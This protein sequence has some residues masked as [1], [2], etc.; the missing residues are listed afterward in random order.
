[1][2]GAVVRTPLRLMLCNKGQRLEER[3]QTADAVIAT[4]RENF[5]S[6]KILLAE[7]L[8][9]TMNVENESVLSIHKRLAHERRILDAAFNARQALG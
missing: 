1:M 7:T 2:H 3:V 6:M 9:L 4:T 8:A 5:E